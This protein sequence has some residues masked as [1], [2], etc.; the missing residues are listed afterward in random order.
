MSYITA[1]EAAERWGI[2]LRYVQR[3]LLEQRIPG[4]RKYQRSWLVPADA[5][6]PEDLRKREK[7]GATR[8]VY[9]PYRTPVPLM[10]QLYA[11]PGR[12]DLIAEK[13]QPNNEL[14]AL[15][16]LYTSDAADEL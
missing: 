13:Q 16:L 1:K 2:S 7:R 14:A 10:T 6:K 15:C 5:D 9:L 4:A 11:V 8:T 12:M 3:L